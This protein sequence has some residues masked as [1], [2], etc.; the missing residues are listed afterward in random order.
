MTLK[1]YFCLIGILFD[2]TLTSISS[3]LIL[4][5]FEILNRLLTSMNYFFYLEIQNFVL[6]FR[7][8]FCIFCL[9]VLQLQYNEENDL[10]IFHLSKSNNINL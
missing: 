9:N 1:A 6:L 10:A 5:I 7:P 2:F 4:Y 3:N 8:P